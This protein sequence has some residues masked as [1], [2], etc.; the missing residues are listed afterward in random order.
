[1]TKHE[2]ATELSKQCKPCPHCGN[3]D[4]A[5]LYVGNTD[6]MRFHVQCMICGAQS[7]CV[8]IPAED[9][10]GIKFK[11]TSKWMEWLDKRMMQVAVDLWNMRSTTRRCSIPRE[12]AE[13]L[14]HYGPNC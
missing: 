7:A 5:K 11:S 10:S 12:Y 2:Y 4:P 14:I 8:E 1:M 13:L 6:S 3:D 9:V